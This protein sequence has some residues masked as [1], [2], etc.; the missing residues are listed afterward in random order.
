MNV[1]Q[2]ELEDIYGELRRLGYKQTVFDFNYI[3]VSNSRSDSAHLDAAPEHGDVLVTN[4]ENGTQKHYN[5][6][7][8]APWRDDFCR[9]LLAGEYGP[10]PK[11]VA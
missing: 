2:S 9:D 10:A 5:A 1:P 4:T 8:G 11:G 6:L 7:H 3:P